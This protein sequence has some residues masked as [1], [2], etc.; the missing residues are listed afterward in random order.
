MSKRLRSKNEIVLREIE[1]RCH[2]FWRY[3]FTPQAPQRFGTQTFRELAAGG[4][5]QKGMMMIAGGRQIEQRLQ[6]A[7]Q[8]CRHQQIL[9]AHDMSDALQGVIDDNGYMI[10]RR[11]VL[12]RK[13]DVAP[14]RR[15]S[16]YFAAAHATAI[17]TPAD[18]PRQPL[19]NS[20]KRG[21]HVE[22]QRG[23]LAGSQARLSFRGRKMLA[24][25]AIEWRTVRIPGPIR[26]LGQ[27]AA[28][29]AA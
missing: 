7:M 14:Q 6:Q 21:I 4:V 29:V 26:P 17:F 22:A 23:G 18:I 2:S 5:S 20:C 3:A 8:A 24:R 15:F 11:N 19:A 25:S 1:L 27:N 9:A 28:D 13:H 10:A 12:T 16:L